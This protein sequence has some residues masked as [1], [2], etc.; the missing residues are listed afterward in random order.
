MTHRQ[1]ERWVPRKGAQGERAA[2]CYM[3]WGRLGT[4][5]G[6]K[7]WKCHHFLLV[8]VNG[9]KWYGNFLEKVPENPEVV[10]FPKS[11]PFNRKFRKFRDESQIERQFPGK[12]FRK[13]VYTLRG[14][15]FCLNLCKF[16]IFYSALASSFDR[17]HSEVDI[18]RKDDGDAYSIKETL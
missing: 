2:V 3:S 14:C 9:D 15:P 5:Q 7:T 17:D 12:F 4:S 18:S 1:S 13:F 10:E 6:K 16:P 11:E 8:R